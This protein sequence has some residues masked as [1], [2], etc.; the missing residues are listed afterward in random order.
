MLCIHCIIVFTH[1]SVFK[2]SIPL[3]IINPSVHLPLGALRRTL[4]SLP[5]IHRPLG[6]QRRAR[7]SLPAI[8]LPLGALQTKQESLPQV[9]ASWLP[10]CSP[11]DYERPDCQEVLEAEPTNFQVK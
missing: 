8:R 2:E 4:E 1:Q 11:F 3:T 5:P 7:G 9:D 10:S 6:A